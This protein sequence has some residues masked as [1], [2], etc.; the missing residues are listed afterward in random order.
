MCELRVEILV[1]E[2]PCSAIPL[3]HL[4]SPPECKKCI[5]RP[6]IA[7]AWVK[8]VASGYHNTRGAAMTAAEDEAL[9]VVDLLGF[10]SLHQRFALISDKFSNV[11]LTISPWPNFTCSNHQKKVD[12]GNNCK[13]YRIMRVIFSDLMGYR[14]IT[15]WWRESRSSMPPWS[16][17]ADEWYLRYIL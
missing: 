10:D 8:K 1:L 4:G 3:L 13:R 9:S 6:A 12:D 15:W 2:P 14:K 16:P 17:A 7:T 11:N 5:R